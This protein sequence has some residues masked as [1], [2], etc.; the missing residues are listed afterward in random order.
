MVR[1]KVLFCFFFSLLSLVFGCTLGLG[2]EILFAFRVLYADFLD[3]FLPENKPVP[4]MESLTVVADGIQLMRWQSG[5]SVGTHLIESRSGHTVWCNGDS[6]FGLGQGGRGECPISS[7][8]D[9]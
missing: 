3:V 8:P 1:L 7:I 2:C 4:S 6:S 9:P 5:Q